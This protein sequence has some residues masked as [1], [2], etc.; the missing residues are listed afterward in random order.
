MVV[1]TTKTVTMD[2]GATNRWLFEATGRDLMALI[3]ETSGALIF[4][5]D[6]GIFGDES[7]TMPAEADE[8]APLRTRLIAGGTISPGT[9]VNGGLILTLAPVPLIRK[10]HGVFEM[11]VVE[12]AAVASKRYQL[13]FIFSDHPGQQGGGGFTR[14]DLRGE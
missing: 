5:D 14:A 9:L 12:A 11:R 8:G 7:T 1:I 6:L 4:S 2:A 10:M 13:W 3:V